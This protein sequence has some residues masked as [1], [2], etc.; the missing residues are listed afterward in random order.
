MHLHALTDHQLS[1]TCYVATVD[2]MLS[3]YT[4]SQVAQT[5]ITNSLRQ[6]TS[7]VHICTEIKISTFSHVATTC[8]HIYTAGRHGVRG[9]KHPCTCLHGRYFMHP[10]IIGLSTDQMGKLVADIVKTM[11]VSRDAA[12]HPDAKLD[13]RA[14]R[15]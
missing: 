6:Y 10:Q 3:R 11:F 13:E 8:V 1:S 15:K 9:Q 12:T 4:L 2:D 14:K 7:H 5:A